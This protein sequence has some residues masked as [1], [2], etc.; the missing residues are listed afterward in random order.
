MGA[1]AAHWLQ[2]PRHPARVLRQFLLLKIS[3]NDEPR[4]AEANSS[5]A[6]IPCCTTRY[7]CSWRAI[8]KHLFNIAGSV[9]TYHIVTR[10]VTI[11]L[12]H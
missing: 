5:S 10:D 8:C 1:P 4:E 11:E 2:I 9:D 3:K 7:S 12:Q 6:S